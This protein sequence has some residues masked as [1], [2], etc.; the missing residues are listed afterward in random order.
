MPLAVRGLII[1]VA[2]L[3]L[4]ES[5]CPEACH[6]IPVQNH[7]Q[8]QH[9]YFDHM[10]SCDACDF[11]CSTNSFVPSSMRNSRHISAFRMDFNCA[12]KR[13]V[14]IKC[15]LWINFREWALAPEI[16]QACEML[17]DTE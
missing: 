17:E 15:Y 3:Q 1:K 6:Q 7:A 13:E 9:K 14:N 16:W 5:L 2:D 12:S 4:A 8:D 10:M 11:T